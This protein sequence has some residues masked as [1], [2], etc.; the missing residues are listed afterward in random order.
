MLIASTLF[1]VG[2]PEILSM[3]TSKIIYGIAL[4]LTF[5]LAATLKAQDIYVAT[6]DEGIGEY[7]LSGTAINRTLISGVAGNLVISGNDLFTGDNNDTD[8]GE[9]GLDGSTINASLIT[10]VGYL[11]GIASSGNN[12]F[13]VGQGITGYTTSGTLINGSQ[14]SGPFYPGN[15]AISGNDIFV[16]DGSSIGEYTTSGAT[17]NANLISGLNSPYGIAISGND[18]FVGSGNTGTIGE[19]TTS[20]ATVNASL[21]SGIFRPAYV[22]ISPEPST[23][24]LAGVG[25]AVLWL[26]RR[27][28]QNNHI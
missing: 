4:T 16:T 27:R 11:S 23:F 24:A 21:I 10:G 9:Y 7:T 28:K 5:C 8:I 3:K 12:L 6:Q 2:D 20:G 25:A 17:I 15:I 1:T 19:Y 14:I 13:V 26:W 22:A 18:I